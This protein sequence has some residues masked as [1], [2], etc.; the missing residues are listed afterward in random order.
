MSKISQLVIFAR[1]DTTNT[2]NQINF[3][4]VPNFQAQEINSNTGVNVRGCFKVL[5][6]SGVR[7]AFNGHGNNIEENKRGQIGITETD[8]ELMPKIL[9]TPDS[10]IRG[11]NN[12][13]QNKES[14][15]FT[16]IINNKNYHV[17]MSLSTHQQENSL[18]FNTM[19]IK[20]QKS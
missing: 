1:I 6:A 3:G 2:Y 18:V 15:L 9:N 19:Y 17:V 14:I 20:K 10:I 12:S 8:F 16:K 7:H 13:R 11:N 4:Q 5:T